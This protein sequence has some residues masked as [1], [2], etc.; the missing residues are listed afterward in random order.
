MSTIETAV[1]ITLVMLV[2]TGMIVLPARMCADTM[3]D[4]QDAIED[5]M[6]QDELISP[7]RLNTFLTG[8]SENY[9]II[10]G[11]FIEEVS[12]EEE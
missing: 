12:D 10:Y 1:V 6:T 8:I 2:L 4:A 5:V 9:R 11:A 7:E 3:N